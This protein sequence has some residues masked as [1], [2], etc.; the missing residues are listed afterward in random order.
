MSTPLLI[1]KPPPPP[2]LIQCC[3][4]M[5]KSSWNH[6]TTL[7]FFWGGG[8]R[9]AGTGQM[10]L[11]HKGK[12]YKIE[13]I[14]G[15]K[16]QCVNNFAA[17]CYSS[18]IDKKDSLSSWQLVDWGLSLDWNGLMSF[19]HH[20]LQFFPSFFHHHRVPASDHKYLQ[21]KDLMQNCLFTKEHHCTR[22]YVEWRLY[23][24]SRGEKDIL[25]DPGLFLPN[26]KIR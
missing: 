19:L 3:L 14:G 4:Y 6:H 23:R 20:W 2:S 21:S 26:N 9:G 12:R 18:F 8:G 5:A 16:G 17:N 22:Y 25:W 13:V 10:D 24:A 7:L 15:W 1:T 11:L